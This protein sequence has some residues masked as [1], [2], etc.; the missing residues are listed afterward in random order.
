MTDLLIR[1]GLVVDGTGGPPRHGDVAV[2]GEFI[3]DIGRNVGER[4]ARV[5]D[6]SDLVVAPGF[7]DFHSHADFTLPNYPGAVNSLSQGV[8]TEVMGVCGF[9]P[10]P[11]SLNTAHAEV[12][13]NSMT[14]L[15]PELAWRWSTFGEFLSEL[16]RVRPPVNC[17]PLVGHNAV[18]SAV[19]GY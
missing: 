6:A 1:G 5:V 14:A 9:S 3:E 12:Y 4:G 2:D 17:A 11:L 8:T 18:R 7:I 10:A 16:E 15:G 19:M 13:R